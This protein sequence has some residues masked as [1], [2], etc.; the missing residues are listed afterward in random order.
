MVSPVTARDW[1][2]YEQSILEADPSL[3]RDVIMPHMKRLKN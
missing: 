3:S 2:L 1:K